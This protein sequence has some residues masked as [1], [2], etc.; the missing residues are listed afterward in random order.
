MNLIKFFMFVA[1]MGIAGATDANTLTLD[2]AIKYICL[3][4]ATGCLIMVVLNLF[5]TVMQRHDA[6]VK[7]NCYLEFL[8]ANGLHE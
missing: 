7:K 3:T 8:I 6:K 5:K 2:E 1:F 4:I